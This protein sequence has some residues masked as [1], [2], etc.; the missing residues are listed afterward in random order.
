MSIGRIP[1]ASQIKG[2][3]KALQSPGTPPQLKAGLKV[4]LK[5]LQSK[6]NSLSFFRN[7]EAKSIYG[8]SYSGLKGTQKAKV[9]RVLLKR[10]HG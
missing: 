5:N 6:G 2:I 9:D 4:R 3:Q 10:I 8:K 7:T 1:R